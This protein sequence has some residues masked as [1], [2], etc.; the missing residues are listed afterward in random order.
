MN[1]RAAIHEHG[2][3]VYLGSRR[4]RPLTC[5]GDAGEIEA[6]ACSRFDAQMPADHPVRKLPRKWW[7]WD[8]IAGCAEAVGCLSA[9]AT[10][11]GLGVGDEPL[12]FYFANYCGKVIATDLYGDTSNNCLAGC[13]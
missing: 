2:L 12:I 10:A 4:T 5:L 9:D 8:Y 1:G 6:S 7:E 11:L 3:E 13:W